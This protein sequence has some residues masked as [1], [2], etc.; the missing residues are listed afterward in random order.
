MMACGT[1]KPTMAVHSWC[2]RSN[3][4]VSGSAPGQYDRR[5]LIVQLGTKDTPPGVWCIV[6]LTSCAS[7]CGIHDEAGQDYTR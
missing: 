5:L 2:T 7:M 4:S 6:G 1:T 3:Y